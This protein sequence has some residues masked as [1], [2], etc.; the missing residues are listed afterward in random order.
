[1]NSAMIFSAKENLTFFLRAMYFEIVMGRTIFDVRTMLELMDHFLL[2]ITW[3]K[4]SK[5]K[6]VFQIAQIQ[7]FN[8]QNA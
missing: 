2:K 7:K 4:N 6:I 3:I 8:A 1:M 5:S